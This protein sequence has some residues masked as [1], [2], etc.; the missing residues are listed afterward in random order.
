MAMYLLGF[1]KK[2]LIGKIK[3]YEK[4]QTNLPSGGVWG[5]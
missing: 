1:S 2:K 5:W 4:R 3:N